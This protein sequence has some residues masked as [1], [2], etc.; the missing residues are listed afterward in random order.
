MAAQLQ[1]RV[2]NVSDD[3]LGSSLVGDHAA[4]ATSLTVLNAADF[5]EDGGTLVINDQQIVYTSCNDDTDTDTITLEAGLVAAA[6]DGDT[7]SVW[8]TLREVVA[9]DKTATVDVGDDY[10]DDIEATVALHL[11]DH[12]VEG[13][14]GD[15]G[16]S[17]VLEL[18][19]D[20]DE[21][22]VVEI[23][24]LGG[25]GASGLRAEWDDTY[26]LTAADIA[27]GT[28]TFTLTHRPAE[29]W[30]VAFLAGVPQRPS[31]YTLDYDAQQVTW[32]LSGWEKAGDRIWVHYAYRRGVSG[33]SIP[34]E[35]RGWK[36]L[37]VGRTDVTNRSAPGLDD[38]SWSVA[39]APFG[40]SNSPNPHPF[41]WPVAVSDFP[42]D[43]A[44]WLRRTVKCALNR[45]VTIDVRAD[46]DAY[47]YWNGTQVGAFGGPSDIPTI[48]IPAEDV[49]SSNT[50]AIHVIDDGAT[51]PD[52]SYADAQIAQ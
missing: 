10:S 52:W 18:D 22:K 28:A 49:A 24:G 38:S 26:V 15:D 39:A 35:S 36:H 16:E 8:D 40:A 14:R 2:T 32:P 25:P 31:N 33:M 50:F 11:V 45:P 3:D 7:V 1:G 27:A 5:D 47:I 30:L 51:S 13:P 48:V 29:E 23:L 34:F 9:V 4:G 43:T 19:E 6:D 42:L 37:S 12:L 44:I 20:D 46:N 21:W 17:V 41:G